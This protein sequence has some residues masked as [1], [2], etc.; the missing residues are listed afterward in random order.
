[1][2]S[3]GSFLLETID[4]L[5]VIDSLT[6][7]AVLLPKQ[8]GMDRIGCVAELHAHDVINSSARSH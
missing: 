1:M 3:Q 6:M 2:I 8:F 4:A 7:T 5:A